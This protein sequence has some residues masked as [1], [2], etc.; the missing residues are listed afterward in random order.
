M[1]LG[2]AADIVAA[3][4]HGFSP[5]PK[6][7]SAQQSLCRPFL[8][9]F[10][11][12][13]STSHTGVLP[14]LSSASASEHSNGSVGHSG[15]MMLEG[16]STVEAP[17][18]VYPPEMYS[19]DGS[20]VET[21]NGKK[22][23]SKDKT[24]FQLALPPPAVKHRQRFSIRPKLLLQLQQTSNSTRPLPVLDV[25][26]SVTFAPRLAKKF[27]RIFK[28]KDGLGADDLVIVRSQTYDGS[29]ESDTGVKKSTDDEDWHTRDF[30]AAFCQVREGEGATLGNTEICLNHG[31][32][33]EASSKANG[34]YE[35]ISTDEQGQRSVA[36]WVPK[37]SRRRRKSQ[38]S[39][40]TPSLPGTE[41][42]NFSIV[43]PD[44]RRHP[45]MATLTRQSLSILDRYSIPPTPIVAQAS[46]SPSEPPVSDLEDQDVEHDDMYTIPSTEV[47]IDEHLKTL[48]VITGLWVAFREGY[49]PYFRY[50]DPIFSSITAA[51]AQRGIQKTHT[52]RNLSLNLGNLTAGRTSNSESGKPRRETRS[53]PEAAAAP[54]A[55]AMSALTSPNTD[56]ASPRRTQST[57][58]A[59]MNRVN[60]RNSSSAAKPGIQSPL[61]IRSPALFHEEIDS[62]NIISLHQENGHLV[63]GQVAS[64]RPG[65]RSMVL[66]PTKDSSYCNSLATV[67]DMQSSEDSSTL[68]SR[69][70]NK[71]GRMNRFLGF[72]R[73]T[74]GAHN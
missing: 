48:I 38:E 24:Y 21:K 31:P 51:K 44:S 22:A 4:R 8:P 25:L 52:R 56:R 49:S 66:G 23:R 6:F 16:L 50:N 11:S 74:S 70:G 30:V 43:N 19:P 62:G 1:C 40:T 17:P 13:Y 39:A 58:T 63:E 34:V 54:S 45:V 46:A 55:S 32:C 61:G 37:V 10:L 7:T 26:P 73:K 2:M 18:E 57:G 28:G 71:N 53:T 68:V 12:S 29:S 9:Y 3:H 14:S 36:R 20:T 33:W 67:S 64:P 59:F 47:E 41:R 42:F 27:P 15:P 60:N 72:I 65:Q 35:F 5:L 69:N